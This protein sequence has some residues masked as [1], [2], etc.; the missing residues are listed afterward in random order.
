MATRIKLR[1]LT[2][3]EGQALQ[4]QLRHGSDAVARKRAA[5][6]LASAA[7]MRPAQIQGIG[8]AHGSYVRKL[9]HAFNAQGLSSVANRYGRGHP[10]KFPA[11]VQERLKEVVVSPPDQLG[12]PF[13]Q[14]SLSKLRQY[15]ISQGVI[16]TISLQHLSWLLR[17]NG[18]SYQRSKTWKQSPDSAFEWKKT[19][20]PA[21]PGAAENKPPGDLLRRVRPAGGASPRR[22]QLAPVAAT[23]PLAGQLHAVAGNPLSAGGL[24][25]ERGSSLGLA[26]TQPA[27]AAGAG[28]L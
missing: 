27:L 3:D 6:L 28:F 1:E 14:W 17:R 20:P 2:I 11:A 21:L 26:T 9:I 7:G 4:R 23:E 15:L 10:N 22:G 12:L 5:V 25:A 24:R 13:G 16:T 8:L 19:H 18:I